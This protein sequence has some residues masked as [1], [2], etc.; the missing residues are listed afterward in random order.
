M[1]VSV[2]KAQSVACAPPLA[3]VGMDASGLRHQNIP[4]ALP[5][6]WRTAIIKPE[7]VQVLEIE[8]K[9]PLRAIDLEPYLVLSSRGAPRHLQVGERSAL[10]TPD[11][12]GGVVDN[13][14]LPLLLSL[15]RRSSFSRPRLRFGRALGEERLHQC[16]NFF[17][18][19]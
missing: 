8:A 14:L 11:E 12:C 5:V 7:P 6:R 9:R 17:K 16:A 2:L 13:R 18:F 4:K 10:E 3:H 15:P 19:T 1:D